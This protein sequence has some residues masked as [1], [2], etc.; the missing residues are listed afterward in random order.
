M[1][2]RE[3]LLMLNEYTH[4]IELWERV[5]RQERKYKIHECE[6][7]K[8]EN[9]LIPLRLEKIDKSMDT[10]IDI[11]YDGNE[12]NISVPYMNNVDNQI[13]KAYRVI[14]ECPYCGIK[15]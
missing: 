6:E 8:K 11:I 10:D 14:S 5:K 15:L 7:L 13:D 3:G 4:Y 9:K 2:E 1:D 12:W